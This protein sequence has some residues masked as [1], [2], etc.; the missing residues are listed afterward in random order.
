MRS[1]AERTPRARHGRGQHFLRDRSLAADVVRNTSLTSRDLVLEIG[2]GTGILTEPLAAR[3]G[4][5]LAVEIDPR[6]ARR[7]R[8]RFAETQHVRVIE[9]DALRLP[10]P[11]EPFRVVANVP[12]AHT[13]P[14]LHRLL[15]DPGSPLLR[16]DLI[17]QWDAAIKRASQ[18][19]STL[20]TMSWA[21][22]FEFTVTRRIP[23]RR[24]AP[25]PRTDAAV[26][27]ITR[28]PDQLLPADE[29]DGYLSFLRAGFEGCAV[30]LRR[31]FGGRR[32]VRLGIP[33]DSRPTDLD[34]AQWTALYQSGRHR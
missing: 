29:R 4:H 34:V 10:L 6:L 17:V 1:E 23:A 11:E 16:A 20:L 27:T 25:R 3:A 33:K 24:F 13:T 12:F 14:I 30:P 22:W 2:A 18:R 8:S 19:P 32:L 31:T 5:V 7:L 9:G 15:D 21:P 26:L 28:R